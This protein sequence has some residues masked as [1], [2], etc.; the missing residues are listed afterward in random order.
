[1]SVAEIERVSKQGEVY[2]SEPTL[3]TGRS[4]DGSSG[5]ALAGKEEV[6]PHWRD[7]KVKPPSVHPTEIE[8]QYSRFQQTVYC[9]SIA[10]DHAATEAGDP[11]FPMADDSHTSI[12]ECCLE[13]SQLLAVSQHQRS[14]GATAFGLLLGDERYIGTG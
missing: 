2:F 8:P 6:H 10:L 12:L 9:A 11:E 4:L 3:S 7:G 5:R 1:M 14:H 13:L